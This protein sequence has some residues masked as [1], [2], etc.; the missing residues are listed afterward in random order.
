MEY[1]RI[2]GQ[3]L[4]VPLLISNIIPFI[5]FFH[6]SCFEVVSLSILTDCKSLQFNILPCHT[7]LRPLSLVQHLWSI[8][9]CHS[10]VV[11]MAAINTITKSNLGRKE[12]FDLHTLN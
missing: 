5:C 11:T 3:K 10:Y 1:F 9:F 8:L 4:Q 6:W 7:L 2:I 12:M